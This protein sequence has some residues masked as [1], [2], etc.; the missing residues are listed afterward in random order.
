MAITK[1]RRL[2]QVEIGRESDITREIIKDFNDSI[3]KFLDPT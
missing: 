1:M 2:G 3:K